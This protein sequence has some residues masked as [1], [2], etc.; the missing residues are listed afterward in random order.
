MS[1]YVVN[2]EEV[3][4]KREAT[5]VAFAA[6]SDGEEVVLAPAPEPEPEAA[7]ETEVSD[8]TVAGGPPVIL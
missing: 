4:T 8:Q 1:K 3:S 7:E 2:G 5:D 6:V